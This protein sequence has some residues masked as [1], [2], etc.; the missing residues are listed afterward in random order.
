M[1][2]LVKKFLKKSTY[3]IVIKKVGFSRYLLNLI[4]QRVFRKN[5]GFASQINFTSTV[6]FPDLI[7][8]HED[9]TT[10]T[11]FSVS[12]GCYFQAINGIK[13]GRRFLF[14]PGVKLISSNHNPVKRAFAVNSAPIEIG[15]D[16]WVGA[17]AIILP[18]VK[19]GNNCIIG[20]GAVVTKSFLCEGLIIAGNPAKIIGSISG[21]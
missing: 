3:L 16:V 21:E 20:A 11:S 5:S 13:I 4:F 8:F 17:N 14:A 1:L 6:I 10:L 18:G 9:V 7:S 2:S 19:I 12:E 15:D